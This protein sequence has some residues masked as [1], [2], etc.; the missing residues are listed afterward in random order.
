MD[1]SSIIALWNTLL[2]E[3]ANYKGH[4]KYCQSYLTA[5]I[6]P[7]ILSSV[8]FPCDVWISLQSW[9]IGCNCTFVMETRFGLLALAVTVNEGQEREADIQLY[10]YSE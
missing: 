1:S 4:I 10:S 6:T 5:T 7:A 2:F 3:R 9:V 8:T